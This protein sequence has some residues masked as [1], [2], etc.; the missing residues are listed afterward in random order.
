MISKGLVWTLRELDGTMSTDSGEIFRER[1]KGQGPL[2]HPEGHVDLRCADGGLGCGGGSKESLKWL[3][4][5]TEIGGREL[6]AAEFG[7]GSQGL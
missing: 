5:K 6:G 3:K 4:E 1:R 2:L 7:W